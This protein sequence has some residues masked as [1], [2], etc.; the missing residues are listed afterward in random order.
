MNLLNDSVRG[1]LRQA[2]GDLPGAVEL[3]LHAPGADEASEVMRSLLGE[4]VETLPA[5]RVRDAVEVPVLEPGHDTGVAIEGPV[6][7]VRRSGEAGSGVRFVGMTVGL[8]FASLVEA[9]RQAGT[10]QSALGRG[11]REA[12]SALEAPVHIQVFTTPSCPYC[13]QAVRIA[14]EMAFVSDKVV[15]DMVDASTFQGL[16]EKYGVMGVPAQY[17]NGGLVQVG[18][19]PEGVVLEHVQR[20]ARLAGAGEAAS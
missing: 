14:H 6:L 7:T 12:L 8:E 2:L 16:S 5:L 10:G 13:P 4:M 9:I 1:Q 18:L 17:F 15:A 11:T 19:A 20:A 3:E